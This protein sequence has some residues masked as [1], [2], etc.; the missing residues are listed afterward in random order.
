MG[1]RPGGEG[2]GSVG[3]VEAG[4]DIVEWRWVGALGWDVI[5]AAS[6]SNLGPVPGIGKE[7]APCYWHSVQ[8]SERPFEVFTL[9]LTQT[10]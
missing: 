10:S 5:D 4:E 1:E 8:L 7:D 3:G 6:V 9:S 2:V